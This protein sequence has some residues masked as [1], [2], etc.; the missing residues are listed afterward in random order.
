MTGRNAVRGGRRPVGVIVVLLA[1]LLHVLGCAHGPLAGAGWSAPAADAL[2]AAAAHG[3]APLDHPQHDTGHQ[4]A[5][6]AGTDQPV[7]DRQPTDPPAA[8]AGADTP[9]PAPAPAGPAATA[10]PDDGPG[11]AVGRSR[12]A[13]GVWRT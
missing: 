3:R 4:E 8:P 2:P 7:T 13:L 11:P 6:C 12:A 5:R 1:A 9:V 10:A